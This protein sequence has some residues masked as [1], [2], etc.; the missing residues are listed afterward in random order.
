MDLQHIPDDMLLGQ[1]M[2]RAVKLYTN[3]I[4]G[5]FT[6]YYAVVS[7]CPHNYYVFHVQDC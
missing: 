4:N 7:I 5:S 1:D 6:W 2:Q 3:I